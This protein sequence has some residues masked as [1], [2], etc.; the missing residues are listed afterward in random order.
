MECQLNCITVTPQN[1]QLK[2][3]HLNFSGNY[4]K[5][6]IL[7]AFRI[8]V[9]YSY[10]IYGCFLG[11]SFILK[12]LLINIYTHSGPK[13]NSLMINNVGIIIMKF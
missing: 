2:I 11:I 13:I 10:L 6:L 9:V 12:T 3:M 4:F 7:F 1:H 5:C 8:I